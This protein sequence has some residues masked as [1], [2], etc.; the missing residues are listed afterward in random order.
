[1]GGVL[2]D[3][4]WDL[5]RCLDSAAWPVFRRDRSRPPGVVLAVDED[6]AIVRRV[7]PFRP[8][9]EVVGREA[10]NGPGHVA[11]RLRECQGAP[12]LVV[13]GTQGGKDDAGAVGRRGPGLIPA[14]R[15][16]AEHP[17][18]LPE[19]AV[20]IAGVVPRNTVG[21]RVTGGAILAT[22]NVLPHVRRVGFQSSHQSHAVLRLVT[23]VR[24]VLDEV[25]EGDD[26]VLIALPFEDRASDDLGKVRVVESGESELSLQICHVG[27]RAIGEHAIDILD[28]GVHVVTAV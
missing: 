4:R 1:M 27:F 13:F 9:V 21:V 22:V 14:E 12:T 17:L 10:D 23:P 28:H 25:A 15:L 3:E 7:P 19:S 16:V 26:V 11:V 18:P 8:H 24:V 20:E 6:D 2:D 5:L